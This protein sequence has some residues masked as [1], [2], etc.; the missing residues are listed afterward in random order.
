MLFRNI[1]NGLVFNCF[2]FEIESLELSRDHLFNLGVSLGFWQDFLI[3][4]SG[5]KR[6]FSLNLFKKFFFWRHWLVFKLHSLVSWKV[7]TTRN[8]K[9]RNVFFCRSFNYPLLF[10][11]FRFFLGR[12]KKLR[13]R[14]ICPHVFLKKRLR[15]FL[16]K[17]L[18][19]F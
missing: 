10:I 15:N 6:A 13:F 3:Q 12:C 19:L 4:W 9:L 8:C 14:I 18:G 17:R 5:F 16:W 2:S 7:R 1:I 11:A